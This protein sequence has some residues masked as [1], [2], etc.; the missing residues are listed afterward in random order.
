MAGELDPGPG[1]PHIGPMSATFDTLAAADALRAVGM[2]SGHARAI[3]TQLRAAAGVGDA[4]TRPELE[5]ALARLK[6]ELLG[7][8]A[9][10]DQRLADTKSELLERI[11]EGEQRTADLKTELLERISEGEQRSGE[12]NTGL[13]GR[14]GEGEAALMGRIAE[15]EQRTVDVRTELLE[16]IALSDRHYA[17]MLWRLFAGVAAV[18]AAAKYLP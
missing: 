2:E 12:R 11:S 17:V 9:E 1:Q 14:M 4:V 5:V 13:L 7:R 15:G 10:S 18:V 8:M 16:R 6:T 3:A